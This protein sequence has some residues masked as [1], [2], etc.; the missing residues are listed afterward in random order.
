MNYM[1]KEGFIRGWRSFSQ[2]N[3]VDIAG[4]DTTSEQMIMGFR[5]ET[6][7]DLEALLSA[8]DL[9]TDGE[10]SEMEAC[11]HFVSD[12]ALICSMEPYAPIADPDYV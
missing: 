3:N 8:L 11:R 10:L 6:Q 2:G 12:S 7:Q 5:V 1:G 4:I 9:D